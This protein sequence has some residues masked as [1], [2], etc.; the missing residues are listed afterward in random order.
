M[1]IP[2]FAGFAA[3]G[4]LHVPVAIEDVGQL[5]MIFGGD[6]ELPRP[7]DAR[8][9]RYACLASSVRA[10]FRNGGRRCWV[11]RVA[12]RIPR[13]SPGE[14]VATSNRFVVP[15]LMR[16]PAAGSLEPAIVVARSEG[17]WSDP[18]R[19]RTNLVSVPFRLIAFDL[20]TTTAT[21]EA[22]SKRELLAGDLVRV[23][24]RESDLALYLFIG[25]IT[26]V[27]TSTTTTARRLQIAGTPVWILTTPASP[28]GTTPIWSRV[29]A[30]LAEP[31]GTPAFERLT[32]DLTAQRETD[33]PQRMASLGFAPW[34]PRWF[35][36]L[37]SD[38]ALYED[39]SQF[40][41]GATPQFRP[42]ARVEFATNLLNETAGPLTGW[43]ALWRDAAT[44]RF[45]LAV[46]GTGE[47]TD[48]SVYLPLGMT[49]LFSDFAAPQPVDGTALERSGLGTFAADLFLDDRFL[50]V[51]ADEIV[52]RADALRY[53]AG[54]S[55]TGIHAAL[56]IEEAT[57][58]A[59]PDAIHRGWT[60]EPDDL[61][62]SPPAS[63]PLAHPELWRW[64][65]CRESLP[66]AAPTVIAGFVDCTALDPVDAPVLTAGDPDG[67]T[68]TLTWTT[69]PGAIEELQEATF[70][71]FS[72][73]A[74]VSIGS[75]DPLK[76]GTITFRSRTAGDYFYRARRIR[77]NRTSDFSNGVAVRV[78][79]ATGF[80]TPS[81]TDPGD[82]PHLLDIHLAMV[83]LCAARADLVALLSLPRH[84]DDGHAIAHA[85]SLTTHIASTSIA[86]Y[87]ALWHPWLTGRD[88]DAGLLRSIPPDGPTA[89]VMAARAIA[90][91]AWVAPANEPLR[92]VIALTPSIPE[93]ARQSLQDAAVNLVRREPAG[94]VCLDADTLST[95]EDV[96]PLNVRRLLIL[97]RRAA[98]RTGNLYTFEPHGLAL[99][100]T[101]KR[102]FESMLSSMFARGAFAGRNEST[103]FQVVTDE[104][105]NTPQGVDQGR[106][107]A[108]L[109]IAPSRPLSFLT[110]RLLQR[111]EASSAV[112]VR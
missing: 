63:S 96:R 82:A 60:R 42:R 9:P 54:E 4:P 71:D 34:H 29:A 51:D 99:R 31:A 78:T 40:A 72:D 89:G 81:D 7:R 109:R 92:G 104:T 52:D 38:K 80:V 97:V 83:R 74:T 13:E 1:D 65:D 26:D 50:T 22:S 33:A 11:I 57:M 105:V 10:F 44:P 107:V 100:N 37:P 32:F 49:S 20:A 55:L 84:Y 48:G 106:F 53:H 30:P 41:D 35:G 43:P 110:I 95:D 58:L 24:W 39:V 36:A 5:A 15:G 27:T 88:D 111:G 64:L 18:V 102:G 28:P 98:L 85:A 108:E 25:T 8:E 45:A 86:S 101:V 23:S 12:R 14:V 94:F 93:H 103:A 69:E 112:E 2:V 56:G 70:P 68:Y 6:V 61:L 21:I 79:S 46:L 91:G 47:T 66:S 87:G 3:S 62:A 77:G 67:G 59:A 76:P 90:R 16:V 75:P 19:V 73:A 17:S